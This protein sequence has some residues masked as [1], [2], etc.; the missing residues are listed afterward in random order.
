MCETSPMSTIAPMLRNPQTPFPGTRPSQNG[1]ALPVTSRH[2]RDLGTDGLNFESPNFN[3]GYSLGRNISHTVYNP[4]LGDTSG[5]TSISTDVVIESRDSFNQWFNDVL[6]V[7]MSKYLP[8]IVRL[9]WDGTY[10]FD[11]AVDEP[12]ASMGG[13][14]PIEN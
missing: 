10:V 14:Y 4:A 6:G 9:Q 11:S 12:Y 3:P 2:S 1:H 8:I 7:N 13:F 5:Q